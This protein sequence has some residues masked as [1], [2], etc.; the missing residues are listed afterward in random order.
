M[1]LCVACR[2]PCS[3]ITTEMT[4]GVEKVWG[5]GENTTESRTKNKEENIVNSK[6]QTLRPIIAGSTLG[7]VKCISPLAPYVLNSL[8][9]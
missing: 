3:S 4:P 8:C 1:S 7:C 2:V 9:P 5:G 6:I